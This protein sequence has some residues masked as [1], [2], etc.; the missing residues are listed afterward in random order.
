MA[1]ELPA[2]LYILGWPHFARRDGEGTSMVD[3]SQP[4]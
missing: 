4:G 3:A 1:E 2:V